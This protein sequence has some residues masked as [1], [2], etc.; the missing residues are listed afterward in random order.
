LRKLLS[1]SAL[2]AV[3][4]TT[5]VPSAE[6]VVVRRSR[7]ARGVRLTVVQRRH[8]LQRIRIVSVDMAA[9]SKIRPVLA[10]GQL[11]G[12]ARTSSM[13]R[14]RRA[15]VAINGDYARPSG[16][17]VMAFAQRGKLMQTPLVWGRNFAVTDDES[18][19]YIGHPKIRVRLVNAPDR[20]SVGRINN[21]PP[22][23]RGLALFTPAGGDLERPPKRSCS[24]R[25]RTTG[26]PSL[27]SIGP[28]LEIPYLVER[29]RCS[30]RRLPLRHGVVLSARR[31]GPRDQ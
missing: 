11:P 16:R 12:L 20:L 4:V 27:S 21:G 1:V 6:A 25:L 14:A 9:P 5:F 26:F 13:A 24:A 7:I 10:T 17:P 19:A 15:L 23:P 2:I 31:W 28:G 29:V 22:K 18:A 3:L 30:D 8:P